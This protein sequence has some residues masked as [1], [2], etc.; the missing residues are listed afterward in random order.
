M[1]GGKVMLS[2]GSAGSID[3]NVSMNHCRGA[4]V[5]SLSACSQAVCC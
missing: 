1:L 3:A 2:G 4:S 5:V